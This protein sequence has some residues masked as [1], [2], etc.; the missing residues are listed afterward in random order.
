MNR[1]LELGRIV[2]LICSFLI[3]IQTQVL[4]QTGKLPGFT[5]SQFF[6]E[7][8]ITFKYPTDVT[9]HINAPSADSMR[10]DRLTSIILFAL[11]NGNSIDW[12]IGNDKNSP[13]LIVPK[14]ISWSFRMKRKQI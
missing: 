11:P 14:N 13:T 1:R 12:T 6:N 7:Q 10:T 9:V 3:L 8:L 5:K 2:I 4:A